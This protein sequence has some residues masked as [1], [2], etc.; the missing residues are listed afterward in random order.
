MFNWNNNIIINNDDIKYKIAAKEI[1]QPNLASFSYFDC[2]R[3]YGVAGFL[4]L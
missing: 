1:G 3:T 4:G 2:N